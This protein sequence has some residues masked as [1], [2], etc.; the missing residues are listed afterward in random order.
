SKG[1]HEEGRDHFLKALDINPEYAE[2]Y[3]NLGVAFARLG[4]MDKA[5]ES[6]KRALAFKPDYREA[7]DNLRFMKRQ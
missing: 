1:N 5:V 6:F 3:N 2:A 4:R 7:Q